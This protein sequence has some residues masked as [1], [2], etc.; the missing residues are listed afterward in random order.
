MLTPHRINSLAEGHV[1]EC[2]GEDSGDTFRILVQHTSPSHYEALGK[3]TLRGGSVHYQSSGPMAP[4]LLVQ[5]LET[6]FDRWPRAK[7][8][9]WVVHEQDERTRAFVQE[10]RKAVKAV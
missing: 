3:V 2:V 1:L 6:L 5:W 10:V 9:P 8:T 4:D 7:A